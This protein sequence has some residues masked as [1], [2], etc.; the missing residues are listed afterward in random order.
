[1]NGYGTAGTDWCI[2]PHAGVPDA[3]VGVGFAGKG[4]LCSDIANGTLYVNGG[5]KTTPAWKLVTQAA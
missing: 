4:S 3:T 2:F 1:M 5:T